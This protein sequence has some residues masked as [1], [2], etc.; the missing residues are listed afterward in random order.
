MNIDKYE[1]LFDKIEAHGMKPGMVNAIL[2]KF[3]ET[4][5]I[6]YINGLQQWIAGIND[7][8][9]EIPTAKYSF[10]ANSGLSG[11][12]GPWEIRKNAIES[13]SRFAALYSDHVYVQQPLRVSLDPEFPVRLDEISTEIETLLALKPLFMAG[14]L[15]IANN[16][17]P[18]PPK[19]E[20]DRL[21]HEFQHTIQRAKKALIE[22]YGS[23]VNFNVSYIGKS[24]F[25]MNI[26]DGPLDLISNPSAIPG[27]GAG[28]QFSLN[29]RSEIALNWGK[30][31]TFT[32]KEITNIHTDFPILF[33]QLIQPIIRDL[34]FMT[35]TGTMYGLNYL[36]D[37]TADSVALS[38]RDSET[39]S[40]NN[41]KL[42][43]AFAH[44]VPIMFD[45]PLT[46]LLEL[47][48][49]EGDS[50]VA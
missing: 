42:L 29:E 20:A 39:D 49:K 43:E 26:I 10:L 11:Q 37:R 13:I 40:Q 23:D 36:T 31:E 46:K 12:E 6:I 19:I 32:G 50:F 5:L 4:Q 1:I 24:G 7:Y 15:K 38:R 28:I 48:K 22:T 27:R 17:F 2:S 47:R 18:I 8:P 34:S 14:I 45:A 30:D 9:K 33:D 44:E 25:L 41:Q 3:D 35:L 16:Y 21:N